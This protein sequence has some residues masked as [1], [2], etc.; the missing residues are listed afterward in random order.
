MPLDIEIYDFSKGYDPHRPRK[1]QEIFLFKN[2]AQEGDYGPTL[3]T[4]HVL[5]E[6]TLY[7]LY[8]HLSLESLAHKKVGQKITRGEQIASVG[9]EKIN[10]GW[11]PHLH[12]QLSWQEPKIADMP[13]VVS[14]KDLAQALQIYPDPNLILNLSLL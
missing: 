12:F 6:K 2:N 7:A 13:G 11:N 5:R 3:I 14:E 8:G 10:G 4:K 1:S 9:D